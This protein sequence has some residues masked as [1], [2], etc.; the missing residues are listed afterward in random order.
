MGAFLRNLAANDSRY[1]DP[2]EMRRL[3][4]RVADEFMH[5]IVDLCVLKEDAARDA[6]SGAAKATSRSEARA[7]APTP[8]LP[9]LKG[10]KHVH[11]CLVCANNESIENH[12]CFVEAA[13]DRLR[14]NRGLSSVLKL[15]RNVDSMQLAHH[16]LRSGPEGCAM[17]VGLLN[18]ANRELCGN[19]W[20]QDGARFAIDENLHRRSASLAR[21]SLLLNLDTETRPRRPDQLLDTVRLFGGIVVPWSQLTAPPQSQKPQSRGGGFFACCFGGGRRKKAPPLRCPQGHELKDWVA[22]KG[23]CDGCRSPVLDGDHVMD[24]HQCDWYICV[25]CQDREAAKLL[26]GGAGTRRK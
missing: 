1:S 19:H 11:L 4:R 8:V 2:M 21:A 12:N 10:P 3:R 23:T 22:Q 13:A 7:P 5:A 9:K 18:G 15:R 20:F 26:S 24:C 25:K 14:D 17:K 6:A 16:L